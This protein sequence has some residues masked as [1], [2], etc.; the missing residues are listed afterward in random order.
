MTFN[1]LWYGA[2]AFAVCLTGG[3]Q[4][5]GSVHQKRIQC[6]TENGVLA[7]DS[8]FTVSS[9]NQAVVTYPDEDGSGGFTCLESMDPTLS[10]TP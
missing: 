1:R 6:F 4:P 5:V 9:W 10:S 2:L 7:V 3:C 8:T